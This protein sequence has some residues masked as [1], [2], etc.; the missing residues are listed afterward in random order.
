[1]LSQTAGTK[2]VTLCDAGK[3]SRLRP[4]AAA[5]LTRRMSFPLSRLQ[6]TA[7]TSQ[8]PYRLR[9]ALQQRVVT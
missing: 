9:A 2:S 5:I 4:A 6:Q 8:Q 7:L 1:M 3:G